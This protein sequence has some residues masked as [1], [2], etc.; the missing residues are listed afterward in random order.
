MKLITGETGF[1][2]T[3]S[4]VKTQVIRLTRRN[5]GRKKSRFTTNLYRSIQY[6]N[7]CFLEYSQKRHLSVSLLFTFPQRKA[8]IF[9]N[10]TLVL[11]RKTTSISEDEER[12]V[13]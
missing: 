9:A 6:L 8:Q 5:L 12:L 4:S 10:D 11:S 1:L 3:R 7:D 2:T 13:E